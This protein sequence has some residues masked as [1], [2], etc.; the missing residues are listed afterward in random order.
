MPQVILTADRTC[1]SLT[2]PLLAELGQYLSMVVAQTLTS[3]EPAGEVRVR[4]V[5]VHIRDKHPWRDIGSYDLLITVILKDL[6]KRNTN[7]EKHAQELT[8]KIKKLCPPDITKF[9]WIVLARTTY[10]SF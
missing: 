7:L 10:I 5:H 6:P 8:E 2:D 4:D 1:E 3:D 9:L